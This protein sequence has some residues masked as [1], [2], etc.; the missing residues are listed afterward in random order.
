MSSLPDHSTP[1]AASQ[2]SLGVPPASERGFLW[3][4]ELGRQGPVQVEGLRVGAGPVT[5]A[6]FRRFVFEDQVRG[7]WVGGSCRPCWSQLP[8]RGRPGAHG[9]AGAGVLG[10]SGEAEKGP[11][12]LI[13]LN[14]GLSHLPG[15]P[16][17]GA[18]G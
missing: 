3:D 9:S 15:L 1:T 7:G 2:V 18:V 10:L 8:L 13:S 5:V 11:Q 12:V 16:A 17:A 4:C 6:Q 14:G